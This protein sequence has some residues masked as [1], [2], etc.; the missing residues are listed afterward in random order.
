[1]PLFFW[2]FQWY[3]HIVTYHIVLIFEHPA[4]NTHPGV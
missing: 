3:L 1:L 4:T 2:L